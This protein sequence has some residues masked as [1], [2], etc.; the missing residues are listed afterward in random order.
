M[1]QVCVSCIRLY[2]RLATLGRLAGRNPGQALLP[3]ALPRAPWLTAVLTV[4]LTIE[5]VG[6]YAALDWRQLQPEGWSVSA[7]LPCKPIRQERSLPLAGEQVAFTMLACSADDHTFA[8]AS[9]DLGDPLQVGPAL[10]ALGQAALANVQGRIQAEQ[11]A[12]VPGMTPNA[13]ARH[14]RV[15]GQL[16]DG[17]TVAEQVLVFAHGTRVFQA[18]LIGPQADDARAQP[19]FDA[20]KVVH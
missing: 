20:I 5:L 13:S 4:V 10:Q 8:L 6:C 7:A 15:L 16:P 1:S 11:A 3:P 17:Q 18:T 14:W 19:F 9:G 2:V 12:A